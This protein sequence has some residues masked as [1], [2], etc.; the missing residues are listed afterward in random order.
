MASVKAWKMDV[1]SIEF[2]DPK[3]SPS[4]AKNAYVNYNNEKKP[5]TIQTPW[6]DVP[7]DMSEYV[8]G[9]STKYSLTLSFRGMDEDSKLRGFHDKMLELEQKI[10]QGGVDNCSAWFRKKNLTKE[11]VEN[12]FNTMI[13]VSVDKETGEPD[14]KW[15]PGMR[16]KI[17]YFKD[18]NTGV[19]SFNCKIQ[20]KDGHMYKINDAESDDVLQDILV[21]GSKVRC[22]LQ[23]VGL[24]IASGNFGCTWKIVRAEVDVPEFSATDGF[25]PD[26]EDEEETPTPVKTKVDTTTNFIEDS[27]EEP[28]EEEAAV[29]SEP[30]PEPV[31]KP[32]KKV[33]KKVVKK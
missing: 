6:M 30:E 5:F 13:K 8:G 24:W 16:V 19:G 14:G 11:V 18:K 26:S 10:I 12:L 29:E 25:L 1:D 9:E 28:V 23:C 21:K 32:T 31:K 2:A 4:G 27:E 33:R 3:V 20:S 7:W 15:P 17:P 22:L